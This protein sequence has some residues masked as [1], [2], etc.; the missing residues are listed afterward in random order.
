MG[1]FTYGS[2]QAKADIEDRAL[3]HVQ[4]V[5]G[6]KLRRGEGFFFTWKD[7]ISVGDGRRTVW[8][9]QAADLEFKYHGSR[10]P[11]M[12]RDW[13]HALAQVANSSTGLYIVPEPAPRP[14]PNEPATA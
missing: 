13:L 9:H 5:M 12:N 14:I 6:S 1:R 2:M 10:T 11:S 3:A 4:A 8:V 7:D